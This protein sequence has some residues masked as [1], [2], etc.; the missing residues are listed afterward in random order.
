[1]VVSINNLS[2]SAKHE[3]TCKPLSREMNFMNVH[4]WNPQRMQAL[5]IEAFVN[6]RLHIFLLNM[7]LFHEIHAAFAC[8]IL[9]GHVINHIPSMMW[10]FVNTRFSLYS[11]AASIAIYLYT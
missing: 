2:P 9:C 3:Y 6:F 5:S 1:M 4:S 11:A 10:N 7:Q 8:H